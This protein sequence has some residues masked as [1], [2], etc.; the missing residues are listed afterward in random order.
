MV[1]MQRFNFCKHMHIFLSSILVIGWG[2]HSLAMNTPT[3]QVLSL[4]IVLYPQKP[5][6]LGEVTNFRTRGG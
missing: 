3:A 1:V 4:N 5:W 6:S 2:Q